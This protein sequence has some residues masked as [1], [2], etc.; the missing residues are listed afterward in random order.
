MMTFNKVYLIFVSMALPEMKKGND[1][2]DMFKYLHKDYKP[3]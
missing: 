3:D 2:G 1:C